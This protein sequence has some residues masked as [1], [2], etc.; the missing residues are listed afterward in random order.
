MKVKKRH[1]NLLDDLKNGRG[2]SH[3][4]EKALDRIISYILIYKT[5]SATLREGRHRKVPEN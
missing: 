4:K 2:Y 5:L 3:L 1:T